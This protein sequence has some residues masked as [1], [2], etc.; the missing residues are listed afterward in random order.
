[1]SIPCASSGLRA[2]PNPRVP[3]ASADG[4]RVARAWS[5][6]PPPETRDCWLA[7]PS[8]AVLRAWP[9]RALRRT[10][11]RRPSGCWSARASSRS[12][13]MSDVRASDRERSRSGSRVGAFRAM[14]GRSHTARARRRSL[15]RVASPAADR[16]RRG[17]AGRLCSGA[18]RGSS[19]GSAPS[20]RPQVS[21][22]RC[23]IWAAVT[24]WNRGPAVEAGLRSAV[25][26]FAG[27]GGNAELAQTLVELRGAIRGAD[28]TPVLTADTIASPGALRLARAVR[29]GWV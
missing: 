2:A 11:P 4:T 20:I 19:L 5:A 1:V 21:S 3:R 24:S 10:V 14:G 25:D 18:R 17:R 15:H 26:A 8:G 23:E 29:V 16:S 28:L 22:R 7:P 13:T 6:V 12:S 9:L 27:D